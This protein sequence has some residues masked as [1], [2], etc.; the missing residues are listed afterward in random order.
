MTRWTGFRGWGWSRSKS[1]S[2]SK[3]GI[4]SRSGD[5]RGAG[6][7]GLLGELVEEGVVAFV[8][9]PDGEV[10]GPGDAALGGLPEELGVGV[11][12][13]F[14]EADV[15]AVNGHGLG[16]SGEGDDAGAVVEFDVADF[17]FFGEG[18]GSAF[19]VEAVEFEV[20][21]AVGE[22]GAGEV[23]EGG[24]FPGQAHVFEGAGIIFSGKEIIAVGVAET[25]ADV[26]EGVGVGPADADG[27]F[28][29]GEDL[30][31]LGVKGVFAE[32][33]GDL[34]GHEVFGEEGVGVD[35]DGGED[36]G[37]AEGVGVG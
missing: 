12:G 2:R 1:K 18:G 32:D 28:G 4:S 35:R 19:G 29:Q 27:F 11:F 5:C 15:A 21:L 33:P 3:I 10:V 24:E 6:E 22:N 9:G 14:V 16:M 17:D 30:L 23:E 13:K 25:F 37:E 7:A 8:G 20:I 36:R 26:L 31:V 34:V